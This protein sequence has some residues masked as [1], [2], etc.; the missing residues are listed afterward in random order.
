MKPNNLINTLVFLLCL[1]A[2][3]SCSDNFVEDEDNP[4][5]II[6]EYDWRLVGEWEQ[7]ND[8]TG[9]YPTDFNFSEDGTGYCDKGKLAWFT[10]KNKLFMK[11]GK[12]K[13]YSPHYYSIY[14]AQ[15][16][17]GND[18][19]YKTNLPFLGAWFAENAFEKFSGKT[20]MLEF[21]ENA[22]C[23]KAAFERDGSEVQKT[24]TWERNRSGVTLRDG[25]LEESM[26]FEVRGGVLSRTGN[27]NFVQNVPWYGKWTAVANSKGEILPDSDDYSTVELSRKNGESFISCKYKNR[28]ADGNVVDALLQGKVKILYWN[29]RKLVVTEN[30]I[31]NGDAIVIDFRT[32]F[33]GE[34]QKLLIQLS[35]DKF[36]T[37]TDYQ[38]VKE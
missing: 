4:D 13:D 3:T 16:S 26:N 7:V 38:L 27:G 37:W 24:Y 31:G 12:S 10:S 2:A 21:K 6:K 23:A 25:F 17:F 29:N 36:A 14:G 5:K 8:I 32:R 33:S 35:G 19:T 9:K 11:I 18:I 28:T 30:N 22:M 34:K 1:F 15:L 20:F